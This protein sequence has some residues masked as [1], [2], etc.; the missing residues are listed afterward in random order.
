[1]SAHRLAGG[2]GSVAGAVTLAV[3][4]WAIGLAADQESPFPHQEHE[5]L[6]PVCTGC[7]GGIETG[8]A[9]EFY[10]PPS[11]CAG[12]HDGVDQ[13][14]VAWTAPSERASNVT[15]DHD[16]HRVELVTAGDPIVTCAECHA[17]PGGRMDIDGAEQLETCWSCHA[18]EREEHFTPAETSGCEVC[19][20]PLAESGF[21]RLRIEA[22][23]MPAEHEDPLFVHGPGEAGHTGAVRA[24]AGRCAT[25]H[26]QDRCVAR[27]V[28]AGIDEIVALPAA[29]P[30]MQLPV[31]ESE[32]P[33]PA[34]HV[35]REWVMSHAPGTEG[36]AE[37]ST[38]HTADDCAS[39]HLE[40]MPDIIEAL[41]SRAEAVAP[42]AQL[43]THA[44]YTHRTPFFLDAH[45]TLAAA[46]PGQCSTCHTEA[47][48]VECH[49]GPPGG[50]Y[51]EPAFVARHQTQAFGRTEEC[52]TCHNT[53]AF[54]RECHQESG[55]VT[56]GRL[57]PGFHDAEPLWLLRHGT[58]ARQSLE[59]CASCHQQRDCVQCHGTIGSFRISPHTD[60]F[61]AADA[62]AR[63]PRTCLAC[64]L[65]NPLGGIGG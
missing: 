41:P 5:G 22:L 14:R 54:C 37:C 10:P 40:P 12:C 26:T 30:D 55:L 6:F 27:H 42:G 62:W 20:V 23:P 34:T 45:A 18:H 25:C 8:N 15:F 24:D 46:D 36:A 64:H 11:Q 58:A 17:G 38:C 56:R 39:C 57:G 16:V 31:W 13:E 7:H 32:Y 3:V 43:E 59:S 60:D 65:S 2:L 52:A 35:R 28:D 1:M 51:H 50:G 4:L 44:P 9:E 61:D 53:A 21:D 29:P 47:Y 63:S 48:C 33:V 49:D 19:H